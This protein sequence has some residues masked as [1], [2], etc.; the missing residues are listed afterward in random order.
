MRRPA[1]LLAVVLLSLAPCSIATAQLGP[2]VPAPLTQEPPPPP[3]TVNSDAGD[4]GGLSTLQLVLIF[5]SAMV[6]LAGI[7]W[8]ILRDARRAAPVQEGRAH[9]AATKQGLSARERERRQRQRR[10]KAKAARQ[11]RKRNR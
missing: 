4:D 7:A 2:N 6:V 9:A 8:I 10:D 3:P 11:Q 1:I 5:G